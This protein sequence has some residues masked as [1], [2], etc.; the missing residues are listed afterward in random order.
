[1]NDKLC[2]YIH[3]HIYTYKNSYICTYIHICIYTY[4]YIYLPADVTFSAA[5]FIAIRLIGT[6]S[7]IHHSKAI[8]GTKPT[9]TEIYVC[10]NIYVN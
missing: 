10:I 2:T 4:V 6:S 3:K 1:M 8:T 5:I 7:L 9:Y